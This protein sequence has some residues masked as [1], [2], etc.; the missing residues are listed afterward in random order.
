MEV[1]DAYSTY[2]YN[3][4]L[5]GSVYYC[6]GCALIQASYN[7]YYNNSAGNGGGVLY[8]FEFTDEIAF[9]KCYFI[10]NYSNVNGILRMEG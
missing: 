1:D 6:K 8:G 2:T 10:D 7:N 3:Q 5:Q 9:Y 4:A